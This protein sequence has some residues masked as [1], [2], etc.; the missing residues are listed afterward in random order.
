MFTYLFT[1]PL[2]SINRGYWPDFWMRVRVRVHVLN[3]TTLSSLRTESG[4]Y[5]TWWFYCSNSRLED[6]CAH[7]C[8][9]LFLTPPLRFLFP[10]PHLLICSGK[11]REFSEP[12][13]I[14]VHHR[15]VLD[16]HGFSR[17]SRT[18]CFLHQKFRHRNQF[19][20]VL[21]VVRDGYETWN[22]QLLGM[23]W[24][25]PLTDL[26][27]LLYAIKM[28]NR[29]TVSPS[30]T[31]RSGKQLLW[32]NTETN[33]KYSDPNFYIHFFIQDFEFFHLT[34]VSHCFWNYSGKTSKA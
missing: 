10:A 27:V 4:S 30:R 11:R 26:K 12:R 33:L 20:G 14:Y 28:W 25:F 24:I 19:L 2:S 16:E 7:T 32:T 5:V 34:A 9:L 3:Y 18:S 17:S 22:L 13:C 15:R 1:L 6:S 31:T 21:V 29:W 8:T 23:V